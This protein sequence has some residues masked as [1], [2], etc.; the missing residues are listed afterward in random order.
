MSEQIV[1]ELLIPKNDVINPEFS[2]V[3][4]AMN[5]ELS[6]ETFISWCKEGIKKAEIQCEIIIVDSS[7][8]K[9]PNLALENGARVL[10]IPKRGLGRAYIDSIPYIRGKYII[11]G[12]AD[13]TYDFREL[14]PFIEKF[15]DG[16]E[17][18]MGSRVKGVIEKGSMPAL[19]R[20]FGKPLT[21]FILNTMFRSNFSDIHCGMR[22]VTKNALIQ[23]NLKS[24]SWEYASEMVIK[25]IQLGL[26]ITEVPINFLKEKAGRESHMVRSGW[27]TP[28]YAGWVNLRAM[29]LFG[30]DFFIFVPGIIM[31][32]SGLM[33]SLPLTF[34]PIQ[35]GTFSLSIHWMLV[36]ITLS[37]IGLQSF[38]L[39][40]I[41]KTIYDYRNIKSKKWIEFLSYERVAIFSGILF[42]FGLLLTITL[43][44]D[45]IS[46][47]FILP[48]IRDEYFKS[49][50]GLMLIVFSFISFTSTLVLHSLAV[51]LEREKV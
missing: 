37:I 43:V 5:E 44:S 22:G 24:Q 16:N 14:G 15:R 10:R 13:C 42:V 34:G 1:T 39:G 26:R 4:P 7:S 29:F 33:L 30:V 46:N 50:L 48:G 45:Y 20:Y 6:I 8:D 21:N 11:M 17:Y 51:T 27:F 18:I 40:L 9:T 23:M 38:F 47:G 36:G 35:I 49:I 25:A 32:I 2:I 12:D 3:I 19:N 41:S 31:L 28:W